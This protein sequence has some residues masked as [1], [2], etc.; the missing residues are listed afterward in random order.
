M[1]NLID[2]PATRCVLEHVLDERGRQDKKWGRQSH[3]DGTGVNA[4]DALKA[5][6]AKLECDHAA[7]SGQLTWRLIFTEEFLEA[8]AERDEEKLET[9]LLQCAAV[10]V[11]WVEDI[12]RRR[13]RRKE[14]KS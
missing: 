10:A 6:T 3:P 11:G 7:K 13:E 8:L 2:E 4:T 5:Q 14:R 12:R 9:E 1:S